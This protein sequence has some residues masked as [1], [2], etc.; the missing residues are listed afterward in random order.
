M[1]GTSENH[2]NPYVGPRAFDAGQRKYFYGRDEEIAILEGLVITARASL[3]F[4]QSGAGKS[5]LLRAGLVPELTRQVQIGRGPRA[6]IYQKMDVLP[7]VSVGGGIPADVHAEIPNIFV[8]SALLSLHP[9]NMQPGEL[10]GLTLSEGLA[11]FL[12]KDGRP[13]HGENEP[14]PPETPADAAAAAPQSGAQLLIFDQFEELFTHYP[15]RWREREGFFQQVCQALGEHPDL[16]VLFTMREDFIAELTPYANLLPQGLR[17]RFRLELLKRE[18]ALGAVTKPAELAGR[19]FAPDVAETLVDNLRRSQPG[20]AGQGGNSN[21]STELG[22]YVEPV[23]LQIVCRQLW[24]KLPAERTVIEEE[25]VQEFGDVDQALTG[26]YETTLEKVL[27][28]PQLQQSLS[29]RRLRAWFDEQLITP[30]R[31]RGLVYRGETETEG[32]PNAA[33]A[34]LNNAYIIRASVRGGDTWYELAHDRLVEPVLAANRA[35]MEKY[36]NPLDRATRAWLAAGRDPGKLLEGAQLGSAEAYAEQHPVDVLPEEKEFLDESCRQQEFKAEQVRQAARR[37]RLAAIIGLAVIVALSALAVYAGAQ[38]RIARENA[39]LAEEQARLS[40]SRQLAAQSETQFDIPNYDLALL[41][42]VESARALGDLAAH[43][44]RAAAANIALHRALAAPLRTLHILPHEEA[45]DEAIWSADESR[46]LSRSPGDTGIAVHVWDAESGEQLRSFEAAE[47]ESVSQTIWNSD[48]DRLLIVSD[49]E[50]GSSVAVWDADSGE[51]LFILEQGD[52]VRQVGW[53]PDGTRLLTL[54][55]AEG[56][57][58]VSLWDADS[59]EMLHTLGLDQFAEQALWGSDGSRLLT[60]G[61]AVR[62]WDAASG[63][64]IQ[65][66]PV[67]AYVNLASWS[68]DGSRILTVT[69]GDTSSTLGLWDAETSTELTTIDV[70]GFISQAVLNADGTRFVTVGDQTRVW[71]V[72]P[73]GSWEWNNLPHSESVNQVSWSKDGSRILTASNDNKAHIWDAYNGAELLALNHG[74]WVN[75]AFM[76]AAGTRILTASWDRTVRLWEF[77]SGRE[78][79]LGEEDEF[80][81]QASWSAD[82][83]RVLTLGDRVGIWDAHTAEALLSLAWDEAG[84]QAS[85]SEDGNR[86]LTYGCENSGTG[87]F[88]PNT[89][90]RMTNQFLGFD[91]S[92]QTFGGGDSGLFLGTTG[93]DISQNWKITSLGEDTYRLTNQLLGEAFALDTYAD[94][95]N[96]PFMAESG[97]SSGQYWKITPLDGGFYR[98]TNELLGEGRALDTAGD[99]DNAPF[100]GQTGDFSGQYWSFTPVYSEGCRNRVRMWDTVS[101]EELFQFTFDQNLY[102]VIWSPDGSRILLVSDTETGSALYAWD[103]GSGEGIFGLEMDEFFVDIIWNP[104]GS[105][106]LTTGQDEAGSKI[107]IWDGATGKALLDLAEDDFIDQA[108]WSEDGSTILAVSR[109]D[110]NV[111]AH[112]WAAD[113]GEELVKLA[114]DEVSDFI[115]W[116]GDGSRLMTYTGDEARVWDTEAGEELFRLVHGNDITHANFNADGTRLLTSSWDHTARL[117]NVDTGAELFALAHDR[118]VLQAGWNSDESRILSFSQDGTVRVWDALTGRELLV[119]SELG[120]VNTAIWNSDESRILALADSGRLRLFYTDLAELLDLACGR[121]TRNLTQAEWRRFRGEEPYALTCPDLPP[122]E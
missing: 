16:H 94:G 73:D 36:E 70:E 48:G 91:R 74:D 63:A 46:V 19:T 66:I 44:D 102:N 13:E 79:D 54:A 107:K 99:G 78:I 115:V 40:L 112:R 6:R 2:E 26:F 77:V 35:W 103:A 37:R 120:R 104:D 56:G 100:M 121:A 10:A 93:D 108:S 3:F 7:V 34:I 72:F 87:E 5:S 24:D 95:N 67:D 118:V 30:A 8:F 116:S 33:V 49:E 42:A 80:F 85:W 83:N 9:Q 92:L 29:Q 109:G 51:R 71:Q 17:S 97:D 11:A 101:G 4:A 62:I 105:R 31:T 32:L 82:G 64:E 106:I 1:T 57:S 41:L 43:P 53:S 39:N 25:D 38:A 28:D 90:Y 22:A 61:D 110:N 75:Q 27:G 98:L 47:G 50:T 18:A 55:D 69:S 114:I 12:E 119:L 88:D 45:V 52:W 58:I 23:H 81:T 96:D 14:A 86:L 111:T 21:P 68:E 59:G 117:W 15:E 76:N 20:R 122:G 84:D 60:S 65:S 113:S 89:W